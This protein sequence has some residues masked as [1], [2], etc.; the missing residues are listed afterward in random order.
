MTPTAPAAP[1]QAPATAAPPRR[2][3]AANSLLAHG[4]P[5]VWLT[6]GALAVPL[7]MIVG[8]LALIVY[9]GG[10]T[11]WPTPVLQVRTVDGKSYLGDVTREETYRPD[12][13]TLNKLP[14]EARAAPRPRSNSR[15]AWPGAGCCARATSI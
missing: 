6:G 3:R 11:F 4:E 8:L 14:P 7:T 13:E 12:D 15:E 1:G 2:Q 9:Q 10:I 5:S